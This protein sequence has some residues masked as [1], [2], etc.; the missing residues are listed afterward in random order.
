MNYNTLPSTSKD[1]F[2]ILE[3]SSFTHHQ[4][5][6]IHPSFKNKGAALRKQAKCAP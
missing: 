6:H 1:F 2:G 4:N 3:G 5:I